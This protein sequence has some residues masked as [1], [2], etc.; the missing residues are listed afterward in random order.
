MRTD[1]FGGL[2]Y[3]DRNVSYDVR[4]SKLTEAERHVLCLMA[5]SAQGVPV[6]PSEQLCQL[7]EQSD[8]N[9]LEAII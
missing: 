2:D 8:K 3:T 6:N 7:Y 9:H 5:V 1:C 4:F